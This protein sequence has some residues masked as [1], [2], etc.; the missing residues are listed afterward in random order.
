MNKQVFIINGTGSSGKDT[1]VNYLSKYIPTYHYSIANLPKEAAT[2]LGWDGGKT[3]R[4][5][6]FLSD[7]V[8][9]STEYN[10]APFQD[11]VSIVTD[12]KNDR[13]E[14]DVLVID[15]R[16]PR[17]IARAVET[18]GAKT[19]FI[20]N[21][22]VETITSNHADRDVENYKYDYVIHNDGTLE[23]LDKKAKEF[24]EGVIGI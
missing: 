14:A 17:D 11:V 19:I 3:E 16:D 15:M 6:K 21:P 24:A 2:L 8:D 22:R 4:D 12:F 23:D 7:M 20:K 10:D 9:I 1:W 18:F 5:R 13:L